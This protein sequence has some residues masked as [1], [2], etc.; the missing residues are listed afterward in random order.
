[1]CEDEIGL[2]STFLVVLVAWTSDIYI[3]LNVCIVS[4]EIDDDDL[5]MFQ[6]N[7]A[8]EPPVHRYPGA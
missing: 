1:M 4:H 2:Q 3:C 8:R 5:Q 7:T 6:T